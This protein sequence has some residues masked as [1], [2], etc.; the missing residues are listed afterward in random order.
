MKQGRR[1]GPQA[2]A[3]QEKPGRGPRV[4]VWAVVQTSLSPG[5]RADFR[6]TCIARAAAAARLRTPRPG[7]NL[8][9]K[10]YSPR[11]VALPSFTCFASNAA[12]HCASPCCL[13]SP[14][15]CAIASR[16][17]FTCLASGQPHS[18]A[19]G[20]LVSYGLAGESFT[21]TGKFPWSTW[22][23]GGA[24]R[25][26]L[27][28]G[29]CPRNPARPSGRALGTVALPFTLTRQGPRR[30]VVQPVL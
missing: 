9:A 8:F 13:H 17:G 30:P 23:G 15:P 24:A 14:G 21:V 1:R 26:A 19:P 2:R 5:A 7:R 22:P 12:A 27:S 29:S 16:P 10:L 6:V 28:D 20:L 4:N 3:R 11:A 18:F 25:H